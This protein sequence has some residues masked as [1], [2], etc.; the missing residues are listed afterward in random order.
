MVR[1]FLVLLL[2]VIGAHTAVIASLL[3]GG[4]LAASPEAVEPA[5]APAVWLLVVV[6]W[7]IA[8]AIAWPHTSTDARLRPALWVATAL[9][10][11]GALAV[12]MALRL[13]SVVM[14]LGPLATWPAALAW[15]QRSTGPRALAIIAGAGL[16][17][18]LCWSVVLSLD[19]NDASGPQAALWLVV[20]D[21]CWAAGAA[22]GWRWATVRSATA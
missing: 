5:W 17:S 10:F 19:F 16:G 12:A 14:L 7:P 20:L 2:A 3:I 1:A 9:P 22:A 21:T 8:M 11:L 6:L 15:A 18:T 4:A 13:G